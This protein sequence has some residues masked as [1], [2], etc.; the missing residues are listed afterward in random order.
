MRIRITL[1]SGIDAISLLRI[2]DLFLLIL[3]KLKTSSAV[4]ISTPIQELPIVFFIKK[5]TKNRMLKMLNSCIIDT[6]INADPLKV[7]SLFLHV[8]L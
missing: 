7:S 5:L 1:F 8:V 6:R 3:K 2:A 4:H